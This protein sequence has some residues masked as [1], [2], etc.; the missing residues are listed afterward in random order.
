LPDVDT[1]EDLLARFAEPAD[2]PFF[3]IVGRD[4]TQLF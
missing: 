2:A 1:K 3:A 4:G